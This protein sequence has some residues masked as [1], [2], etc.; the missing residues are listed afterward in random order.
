MSRGLGVALSR[1]LG[2]VMS[3]GLGAALS[4]V[5]CEGAEAQSKAFPLE[6]LLPSLLPKGTAPYLEGVFP[7]QTI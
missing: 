4:H 2:A 7:L 5:T 6:F 3:R 1:G